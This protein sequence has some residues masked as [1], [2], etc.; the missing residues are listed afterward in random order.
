MVKNMTQG[1]PARLII[2]F[3][4]PMFIGNIFQQIYNVADAMIVGRLIG[5]D[6][7]AAV[8]ASGNMVS[9]LISFLM[10]LTNGASIII[11]QCFG[12]ENYKRM[13]EAVTS[14]IYITAIL[15]AAITLIGLAVSAPSLRLMQTPDEIYHDALLYLRLQFA[16]VTGMAA[17]NACAAV[18][19]SVGDSRTPLFML[20]I[21]SFVNIG[22]DLLFVGIFGMGVAGAALAT[23][24]AQLLSAALCF[25]YIVYHRRNIYLEDM[26]K[27]AGRYMNAQIFRLGIPTD[28]QSSLISLGGMSVQSLVNSFGASTMAA[29]TASCKIDSMAIQP[30]VSLAT[31]LSVFTGHNIGRGNF[32]RIKQGLRKTLTV[33]VV[34][35]IIIA[36]VIVTFRVPLLKTFLGNADESVRQGSIYLAIICIAYIIAGVMHSFLIVIRGAGV[37]NFSVIA[38]IIELSVRIVFAYLLAALLKTSTGIWIATPIA[39]GTACAATVIRYYS[40][41]WKKKSV[42]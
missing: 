23:V 17:Y 31:A 4:V 32:E 1:N 35:C 10:G 40:G 9:F 27:Q 25:S 34:M 29:F 12:S 39:W 3:A 11:S 33:M 36:A 6:A 22:C 2:G 26:P 18:L 20:I 38:G 42:V 19:R 7:L 28:L 13:R 15:S 21:S 16:G 8:G 41:A 30:V 5:A 24:I 14:L 37:V